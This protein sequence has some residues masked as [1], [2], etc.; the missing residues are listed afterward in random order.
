MCALEG[1]ERGVMLERVKTPYVNHC[2]HVIYIPKHSNLF[3]W[4]L[5]QFWFHLT[6]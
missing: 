5:Q 4:N 3:A 1:S 6:K 2:Q